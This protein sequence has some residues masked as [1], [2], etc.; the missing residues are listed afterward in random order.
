MKHSIFLLLIAC[1]LASCGSTRKVKSYRNTVRLDSVCIRD[2]IIF[3]DSLVTIYEWKMIDSV[4]IHDS[5]VLV[6][7]NNGNILKRERYRLIERERNTNKNVSNTQKQQTENM[8]KKSTQ[9]YETKLIN[10][11]ETIFKKPRCMLITWSTLILICFVI[12]Y[13]KK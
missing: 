9:H 5:T 4:C 2:S 7:D 1:V 13:Y 12:W 8:S 6:L 11:I 3:K 10:S